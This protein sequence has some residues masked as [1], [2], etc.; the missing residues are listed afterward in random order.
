MRT[1]TIA[2]VAAAL[3]FT[4]T[5]AQAVQCPDPLGAGQTRT[6]D[7]VV[8][9]TTGSASCY[10]SGDGNIEGD[11]DDF[12]GWTFIEKDQGAGTLL[13]G[14]ANTAT[15][16]FTIASSVWDTYGEILIGFKSGENASPTWA[17]FLLSPVVLTGT[18]EIDPAQGLSHMNI[19]GRGTPPPDDDDL[20]EP[21]T[22]A[23]LG[24]G[25]MGLGLSRRRRL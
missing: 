2:G 7:V 21:G 1:G 5:T 25:L 22:L 3:L 4:A 16:T 8:L 15:G 18:W 13:S 12:A 23:L 20:P 14:F 11:N 17:A 10:A 6:Y 24:L 19:Y 9:T